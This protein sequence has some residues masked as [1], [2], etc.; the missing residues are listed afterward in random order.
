MEELQSTE[1][2]DREILEDARKKALKILKTSG[3]SISAAQSNWQQKLRTAFINADAS[4][5]KKSNEYRNEVMAR[6]PMDKQ[7]I[8]LE[9]IDGFLTKT[10]AEFLESLDRP[11][12]LRI[13]EKYLSLGAKEI[14]SSKEKLLSGKGECRFC[15]L[16]LEECKQLLGAA[17][18]GVTFAFTE[19]PLLVVQDGIFP[20]GNNFPAL[21]IDFPHARLNV[22]AAQAA[23]TLLLDNRAELVTALLGTL[24]DVTMRK[25]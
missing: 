17:F 18:S 5:T 9:T 4:Y 14:A 8:R 15:G 19:D 23:G 24:E 25:S 12:L 16:F 1:V 2:L 20:A 10:M 22:S 3:E 21:V 7:R 13:L 11:S 6:L